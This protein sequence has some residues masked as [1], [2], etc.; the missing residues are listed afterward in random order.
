MTNMRCGPQKDLHTALS[1]I[2]K[3]VSALFSA[4]G[5]TENTQNYEIY[6]VLLPICTVVTAV[7]GLCK[8]FS[9]VI[10]CDS[11][12]RCRYISAHCYNMYSS[13]SC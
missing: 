3:N 5:L 4:T 11:N 12:H 2:W 1:N 9:T 7:K 8:Y 6:S 10:V 13:H